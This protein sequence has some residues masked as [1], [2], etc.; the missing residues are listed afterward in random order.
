MKG[1][2]QE[3]KEL[4][5]ENV[6]LYVRTLGGSASNYCGNFNIF[7][8]GKEQHEYTNVRVYTSCTPEYGDYSVVIMWEDDEHEEDFKK[9]DLHGKYSSNFQFF[10]IEDGALTFNDGEYT[11]QLRCAH[12]GF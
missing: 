10:K 11:I 9:I 3:E 2:K 6:E 7:V 12:N 8:D 1:L 5:F 4:S